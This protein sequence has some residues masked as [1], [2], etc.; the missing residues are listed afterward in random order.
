MERLKELRDM[1]FTLI[2]LHHTPKNSDRTPKRSTAIVDL[3]DHI[4]GLNSVKR[5]KD[6]QEELIEDDQPGGDK[7]F[8]LGDREKTRFEPYQIYL[9][10]N[11]DLGF[12]VAPGPDDGNLSLMR[13]ILQQHGTIQKT[14]PDDGNLSLMR[15]ILQQ[16]GAIQKTDFMKKCHEALTKG[17]KKIRALI[18]AG[19][20]RYWRLEKGERNTVMVLPFESGIQEQAKS[21]DDI[22]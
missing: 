17:E 18:G 19:D 5:T 10:F 16:H 6:G 9:T 20:G 21:D 4:L 12:E 13:D 8:R 2:V 15:G 3:A 11:P 1:G 14:D 7:V 22:L